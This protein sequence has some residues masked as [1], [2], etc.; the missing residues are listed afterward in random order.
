MPVQLGPGGARQQLGTLAGEAPRQP[1]GTVT[2][3]QKLSGRYLDA[4]NDPAK[5]DFGACTVAAGDIAES[6]KWLLTPAPGAGGE[7]EYMLVQ[8][9]TGRFLDACASEEKG[10]AVVTVA[11]DTSRW[12]L[13]PLGEN[14]DEYTLVQKTSGRYLDAYTKEEKGFDA[15]T[16]AAGYIAVSFKWTLTQLDPPPFSPPREEELSWKTTLPADGAAAARVE[17]LTGS[18]MALARAETE[19]AVAEGQV[20]ALK[21]RL[22]AVEGQLQVAER[23]GKL[24]AEKFK[25]L[26]GATARLAEAAEGA[27]LEG[28]R[29]ALEDDGWSQEAGAAPS[30]HAAA[31]AA[32][33]AAEQQS[34]MV[35]CAVSFV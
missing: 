8:K 27:A 26:T 9:T 30:R 17:A 25:V 19:L 18:A 4:R 33:A 23:E 28:R 1:S 31:A 20:S 24:Q 21:A 13:T 32:L 35:C 12:L 14:S 22:A 5:E 16:V 10:Y 29:A 7:N 11:G 15:V 2:L 3:Q 6:F 34:Q